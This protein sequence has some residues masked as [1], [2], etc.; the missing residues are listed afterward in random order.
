MARPTASEQIGRERIEPVAVFQHQQQGPMRGARRA[1]MST[2]SAS[3]EALRSAGVQA[4]GQVAY[5]GS[6]GQQP[7]RA[8]AGGRR[9]PGPP[10][11]ARSP[12][13]P[14]RSV[15]GRV[16]PKNGLPDRAP[17]Q[18]GRWA[19]RRTGRP[20][21]SHGP[22]RRP[23]PAR[24]TSATSRLLPMP[25]SPITADRLGPCPARAGASGSSRRASS[26]SRPTRGM[27]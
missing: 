22:S 14:D 16:E 24:I 17:G 19:C 25:A 4:G 8:G 2:S 5:R 21:H 23:R 9:G 7:G 11:P 15:G 20:R 26:A 6:P 10:P 12:A 18:V 13:P 27:S 1:A 3:R